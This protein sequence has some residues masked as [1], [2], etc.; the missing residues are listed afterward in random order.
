MAKHTAEVYKLLPQQDVVREILDKI[1]EEKKSIVTV[2]INAHMSE[3][4]MGR[5]QGLFYGLGRFEAITKELANEA[6]KQSEE[7]AKSDSLNVI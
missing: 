3:Y 2:L 6:Q 4:E 5:Q 7:S 1:D